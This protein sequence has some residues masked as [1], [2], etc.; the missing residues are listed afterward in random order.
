MT[1]VQVFDPPLCCSSG[2]CGADVD[3]ALVSFAADAQWLITQ[4]VSVSRHNLAQEP[5][6][7]AAHPRVAELLAAGGAGTLPVTIIG[8]EVMSFGRYPTRDELARWTGVDASAARP[9]A[10]RGL[11]VVAGTGGCC[12][13]G[14]PNSAGISC[15]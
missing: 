13:P 9:L 11:N 15:C 10:G 6:V 5:V 8:G 14:E 3:D 1:V 2:V 12:T 4:G 7:F